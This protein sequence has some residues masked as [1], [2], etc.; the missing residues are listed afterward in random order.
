MK[1]KEKKCF[2][3]HWIVAIVKRSAIQLWVTPLTASIRRNKV[4]LLLQQQQQW[5]LAYLL[6]IEETLNHKN[7]LKLRTKNKKSNLKVDYSPISWIKGDSS[8]SNSFQQRRII[9]FSKT[10][11]TIRVEIILMGLLVPR[12]IHWNKEMIFSKRI[13]TC[14]LENQLIYQ[15]GIWL[16]KLNKKRK[17]PMRTR[18]KNLEED[19]F[20]KKKS[21]ALYHQLL[22][23]TI[24]KS[25]NH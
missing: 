3:I 19:Y 18:N 10:H 20:P 23:A 16:E 12:R 5:T 1:N 9:L 6:C 15:S 22:I 2:W 13:S 25:F 24:I 21:T 11:Q 17:N 4:L 14:K 8:K 7:C